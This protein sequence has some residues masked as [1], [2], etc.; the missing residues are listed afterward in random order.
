M[1][2]E[3]F[4]DHDN[5][6]KRPAP[7]IE[8]TATEVLAEPAPGAD[9]AAADPA[10]SEGEAP[11][12]AEAAKPGRKGPPPRTSPS[13]LR[14]FVTHLAAGLLGGLIGV[15]ALALAWSKLPVRPAAAPD[16][17]A[18]EHRLDTLEAAPAPAGNAEALGPIEERIKILE[19]RKSEAAPDLSELT[20]RVTSLEETLDA[21]AK[22]AKDGGS[23][24]DAAAL[25]AKLGDI[26]QT[27]QSKIDSALA[28]QAAANGG[29]LEALKGAVAA[30]SAK[31]GALAEAKLS[32]DGTDLTSE[33]G[34]LDQRIATLEAALPALSGAIDR[35][36]ATAK[37]GA[38]AIAFAN[39]R[40]AVRAGR[41]Y[42]AELAA[43][44]VLAP[45]AE[46]LG[47]LPAYAD[48][49]IATLPELARALQ[50]A[51]EASLA[52]PPPPAPA[53]AS[54]L[55]SV[56]ASAKSAVT[57]RRIDASPGAGPGATLAA[58]ETHLNQGELAA[59]VKEVDALPEPS[60][61]AFAGWL[62]DAQ[63]RLSADAALSQLESALLA[64]M[65]GA[66]GTTKP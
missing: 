12:E 26:E 21:L 5:A 44:R 59:A 58:A 57:V 51:A 18:L 31:L 19:E 41:P 53:Q 17:S 43:V 55:D 1:A 15:L 36:A 60:R 10:A 46:D 23:V 48:T 39:L 27:L 37:S 50:K 4:G 45:E 22:S 8:G 63:A 42:A 66:T 35:G 65:G 14:G 13:E 2:A 61:A 3:P 25:D 54:F 7:T 24:A 16:V 9:A 28:A 6:G 33:L 52:P 29:D 11:L 20:G 34:A 38:A 40:D 32:G 64:S 62:A 30:L 47:V 49:G 56:I